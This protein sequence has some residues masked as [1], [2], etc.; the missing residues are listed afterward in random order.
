MRSAPSMYPMT[1]SAG[2]YPGIKVHHMGLCDISQPESKS[3]TISTPSRHV[4]PNHL[5]LSPALCLPRHLLPPHSY[6]PPSHS[7]HRQPPF[8]RRRSIS[9]PLPHR[10]PRPSTRSPRAFA[11]NLRGPDPGSMRHGDR[12]PQPGSLPQPLGMGFPPRLRTRIL[13]TR[14]SGVAR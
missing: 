7:Q 3:R 8:R 13:L 9:P 11:H 2:I 12:R 5:P 10:H 1:A 4:S 6:L 14:G